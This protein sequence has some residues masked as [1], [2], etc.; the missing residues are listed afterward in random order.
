MLDN[1]I[2]DNGGLDDGHSR[3]MTVVRKSSQDYCPAIDYILLD[4][5]AEMIVAEKNG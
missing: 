5:M 3:K 2:A 1:W 4:Y